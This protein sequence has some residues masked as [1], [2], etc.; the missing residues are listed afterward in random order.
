ME[1]S[2]DI[3]PRRLEEL[4]RRAE[5][6]FGS[7]ERLAGPRPLCPTAM[8]AEV[9]PRES[10]RAFITGDLTCLER[11]VILLHYAE[12][13]TAQEI[14]ATLDIPASQVDRIRRSLKARIR[15]QVDR[16]A[17]S[18]V[19]R[20][21][22]ALRRRAAELRA[23]DDQAAM[24]YQGPSYRRVDHTEAGDAATPPEVSATVLP[25]LPSS[26]DRGNR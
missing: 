12:A 22:G 2:I 6:G 14:G 19:A 17:S 5:R 24:E 1:E 3:D 9:L 15:S 25:T 4:R 7:I 10:L 26:Q 21:L 16:T 8:P 11:R 18:P 23:R 13:M 20:H